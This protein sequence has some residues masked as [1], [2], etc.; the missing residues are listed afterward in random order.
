MSYK[1]P[2]K[3]DL[4]EDVRRPV[5]V[6]PFWV[7]STRGRQG[8][9]LDAQIRSDANNTENARRESERKAKE[10]YETCRNNTKTHS[11]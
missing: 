3:R 11:R 10:E 8:E 7:W 2:T 4:R 9:R 1:I 5:Q 6:S